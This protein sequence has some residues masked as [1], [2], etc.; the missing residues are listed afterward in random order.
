[1]SAKIPSRW[2]LLSNRSCSAQMLGNTEEARE[3][4]D[5]QLH[6]FRF[7]TGHI[8]SK[9][10]QI[11]NQDLCKETSQAEE[12]SQEGETGPVATEGGGCG[13]WRNTDHGACQYLPRLKSVF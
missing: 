10:C 6:A 8:Y 7:Y 5:S 3:M 11:T 12:L 1:M 2:F 13:Y 4:S 9:V